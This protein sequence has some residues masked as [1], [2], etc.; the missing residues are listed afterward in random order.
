MRYVIL[1]IVAVVVAGMPAGNSAE[2][3]K[4]VHKHRYVPE[5]VPDARAQ[6]VVR[7]GLN[8]GNAAVGGNNANSMSGSNSAVNNPIGRSSGSGFGGR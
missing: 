2:A 6:V 8:W 1:A 4:K 7:P 3:A 5:F